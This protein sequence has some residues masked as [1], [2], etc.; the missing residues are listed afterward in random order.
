MS[1]ILILHKIQSI[2]VDLAQS[3]GFSMADLKNETIQPLYYDED[4]EAVFDMNHLDQWD[5]DYSANQGDM[6]IK[7]MLR[8]HAAVGLFEK[9]KKS[10]DQKAMKVGLMYM[11]IALLDLK[12]ILDDCWHD[13]EKIEIINASHNGESIPN[14]YKL[15]AHYK[16]DIK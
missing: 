12:N 3:H 4:G 15:P 10:E 8:L 9:A 14:D 1:D 2:I 11:R 13:L 5:I 7:R 6:F 16:F